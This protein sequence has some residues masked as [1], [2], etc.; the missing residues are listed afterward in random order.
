MN[1]FQNSPRI[2]G[3]KFLNFFGSGEEFDEI[4]IRVFFATWDGE[5]FNTWRETFLN[6]RRNNTQSKGI[7]SHNEGKLNGNYPKMLRFTHKIREKTAM[8]LSRFTQKFR[9]EIAI[10]L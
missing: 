10:N 2:I 1:I 7:V 8:H 6:V 3:E 9:E 4:E 5:V